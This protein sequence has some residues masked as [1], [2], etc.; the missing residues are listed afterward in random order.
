MIQDDVFICKRILT[1]SLFDQNINNQIKDIFS[2]TLSSLVSNVVN[3]KYNERDKY[4]EMEDT[5][6][7]D[8][9]VYDGIYKA[10][11]TM[12]DTIYSDSH[13]AN[14]LLMTSG[15]EYN[16]FYLFY[17]SLNSNQNKDSLLYNISSQLVSIMKFNEYTFRV[18]FI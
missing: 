2:R 1:R 16:D 18:N 13:I 3:L 5:M 15:N 4:F 8:Q 9:M 7:G 6:D 10:I 17:K 14:S 11:R 12:L